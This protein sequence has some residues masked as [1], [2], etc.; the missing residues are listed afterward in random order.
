MS[1][2]YKKMSC[3]WIYH[4][5]S[6]LVINFNLSNSYG[7]HWVNLLQS[8]S[9]TTLANAF[10]SSLVDGRHRNKLTGLAFFWAS[11]VYRNH[12]VCPYVFSKGNFFLT[13]ELIL[14]K[15]YTA[16]GCEWRRIIQDR[17]CSREITNS[18]GHSSSYD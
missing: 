6:R 3:W 14:M 15:L 2:S 9:C 1:P 4:F 5:N 7:Q 13:H 8:V 16:W 11:G 10:L 12:L 17:S 18:E